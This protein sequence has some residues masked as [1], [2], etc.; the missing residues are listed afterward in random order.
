MV[1]KPIIDGCVEVV[2]I[3]FLLRLKVKYGLALLFCLHSCHSCHAYFPFIPSYVCPFTVGLCPIHIH[4]MDDDNRYRLPIRIRNARKP[5]T[6]DYI[7]ITLCAKVLFSPFNF[8]ALFPLWHPFIIYILYCIS[9]ILSC[10][11][12]N[13]KT[14]LLIYVYTNMKWHLWWACMSFCQST[15]C[16]LRL[17]QGTP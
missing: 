4:C 6:N 17:S 16:L 7:Y 9:F 15:N 11:M 14:N 2:G 10:F 5:H 3:F 1:F 12:Q 13:S 8:G